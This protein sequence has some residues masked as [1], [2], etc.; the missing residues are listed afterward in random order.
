MALVDV[1]PTIRDIT[2]A[3][4]GASA[5][6][7]MCATALISSSHLAAAT[8]PSFST[9]SLDVVGGLDAGQGTAVAISVDGQHRLHLDGIAPSSGAVVWSQPFSGSATD[10]GVALDPYVLDNVVIDL[11]PDGNPTN[12]L[13]DV[14]GVNATTGAI[15]WRG[16]QQQLVG[17]EAPCEQLT[18]FCVVEFNTDGSS[19]LLV[20]DP[21]SGQVLGVLKG[22]QES[23]DVDL[24]QTED[25]SE[26]IE[27][28]SPTGTV[29]WKKTISQLFGTGF[30]LDNGWLFTSYGSTEVAT[31]GPNAQDHSF[32]LDDA[33]TIGFSVGS[34][35]SRWSVGGQFQCGGALSFENPPFLCVTTGTLVHPKDSNSYAGLSLVLEGFNPK[36]GATSWQVPVRD[37][38]ALENGST[39]FLDDSHVVVQLDNGRTALLDTNDGTTKPAAKGESV[40][41]SNSPVYKVAVNSQVSSSHERSGVSQYFPCTANGQATSALPSSMPQSVGVTVDGVFLW[42]SPQGLARHAVSAAGGTA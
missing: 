24:Y 27:A 15:A 33:K 35:A 7:V 17:D 39:G 1:R 22:A 3:A 21:S 29:A 25:K 9:T 8:T 19:S 23:V 12:P 11:V 34:G 2:R 5:A 40:W 38:G 6:V 41:C 32:G 42:P 28:L 16:P 26:T 10:P 37:V 36:T 14:V 20:L 31:V 4:R 13:V 30:D 18:K